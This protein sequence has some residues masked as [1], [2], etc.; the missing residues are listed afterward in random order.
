[1]VSTGITWNTTS[2]LAVSY[3]ALFKNGSFYRRL[4]TR[5]GT[6]TLQLEAATAFVPLEKGDYFDIRIY[7]DDST[8]AA[9]SVYTSAGTGYNFVTVTEIPD[10]S[11]FS[12]YGNFEL[13]TAT[14]SVKTPSATGHYHSH[15][16]NSIVLTPGTWRLKCYGKFNQSGTPNYTGVLT[17]WYGANGGDSASVP[18]ALSTVTGLTV[19]TAGD[20]PRGTYFTTSGQAVDGV[21]APESIVRVTQNATVYCGSY[22]DMGTAASARI[23][24]YANAERLQ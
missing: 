19:L 22:A 4:A 10:F 11:V 17:A 6:S 8:S 18:A 3:L 13:V 16:G 20:V 24:V 15:T 23:T 14:S 5:T 1:M 2:N 9:R 21:Q 12:V 7:Q